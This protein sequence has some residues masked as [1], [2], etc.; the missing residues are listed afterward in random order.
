MD[1]V[2]RAR[3]SFRQIYLLKV[4]FSRVRFTGSILRWTV[5]LFLFSVLYLEGVV[6]EYLKKTLLK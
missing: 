1:P 5:Y 3:H 2:N 4:L 6:P